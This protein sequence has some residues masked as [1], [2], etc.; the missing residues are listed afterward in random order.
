MG[1]RV[2]THGGGMQTE[3]AHSALSAEKDPIIVPY[4]RTVARVV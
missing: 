3:A 4:V 2:Q 1:E